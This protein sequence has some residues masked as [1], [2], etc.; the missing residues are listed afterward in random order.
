S[1]A[2]IIGAASTSAEFLDRWRAP[3]SMF[4][5]GWEE[6]FGQE[7]Y[8]PLIERAIGRALADAGIESADHLVISS[9]HS[10]V[11]AAATR[12]YA[13]DGNAD[14][15][16]VGYAGTADAALKL[17]AVLDQ[18]GPDETILLVN[19]VD[20]A[21]AIVLRTRAGAAAGRRGRSLRDGLNGGREI[22]Y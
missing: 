6:R 8:M 16:A 17:T 13:A 9:P 1:V 15:P 14:L 4:S 10:R 20:G 7:A 3:G 2:E 18:T 22:N 11:A 21:D 12:K 19:A 5:D